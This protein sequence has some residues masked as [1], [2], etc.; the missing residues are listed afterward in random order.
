MDDSISVEIRQSLKNIGGVRGS[1]L[2]GETT[3][4]LDVLLQL[5]AVDVIHE[6]INAVLIFPVRNEPD[7]GRVLE[8]AMDADLVSQSLAA[9]GCVGESAFADD[10]QGEDRMS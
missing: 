10:F 9:R 1:L 4:G 5:G 2:F 8:L 6:Q 3:S 7:D